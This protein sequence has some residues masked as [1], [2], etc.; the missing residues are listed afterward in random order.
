MAMVVGARRAVPLFVLTR[1]IFLSMFLIRKRRFRMSQKPLVLKGSQMLLALDYL[2][3][4]DRL[5]N[6]DG[7]VHDFHSIDPKPNPRRF[8][9]AKVRD[10]LARFGFMWKIH[11]DRL[12]LTQFLQMLLR[13]VVQEQ[14]VEMQVEVDA[15]NHIVTEMTF[16]TYFEDLPI[17]MR[18]CNLEETVFMMGLRSFLAA[19]ACGELTESD[20]R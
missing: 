4:V 17:E 1:L 12:P 3:F 18:Q 20:L 10:T 5:R 9:R 2:E 14:G 11:F 19:I 13:G 8:G 6:R 16:A 15:I 7:R